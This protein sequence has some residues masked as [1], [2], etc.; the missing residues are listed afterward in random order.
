MQS[1]RERCGFHGNQQN[2]QSASQDSSRLE[3]YRHQSQ[4]GPNCERQ[5]QVTKGYYVQTSYQGY[6]DGAGEKYPRGDKH[7]NVQ[8]LQG[9][10]SF[11][12]FPEG[13]AYSG[14]Y[15]GEDGLQNWGQSQTL[16]GTKYEGGLIKKIPREGRGYQDQTGQMQ[17]RSHNLHHPQQTSLPYA[18][19]PRQKV[20]ND[21]PSS[22]LSFNQSSHF[23]QSFPT[24]STYSSVPGGSQ[25]SHSFKSCTAPSN[26]P[27]E[28]AMAGT[29]QRVQAMHAY[30]SSRMGSYEQPQ[31]H[32][33][34]ETLHYQ[35]MAKYQHYNQQGQAY[36][37][38][39][40]PNRT[41]EQYYQAFSPSSNHSPGRSV[42]RS[43]S[44]SSTPS[45][46]M[47]NLENFQYNQQQHSAGTFPMGI[48]E[49]SH[50]MPLLNPS[51]TGT[52]SPDSQTKNIQN[53]KIPETLLSDLSLQSLTALT[54]QVENISNTVQQLLMSKTGI[55]Q[56]K[57]LK[58]SPR[59]PEQMKGQHCSPENNTYSS[60]TPQSVQ[61]EIQ[62]A[63]YLSGSEDQ[64]ERTYLYCG[65]SRS[66]GRANNSKMKP[67]SISTCSVT[68]PD[69]MSTKSDDSFQSIHANLPLETFAKLVSSE[70]E[71]PHLLVN[72]LSHEELSTEII[73]LQDAIDN[74][75]AEK[76]WVDSPALNNSNNSPK[77]P[78]SLEN[79][80]S[81]VESGVKNTWSDQG[82]VGQFPDALKNIPD[83]AQMTNHKDF[84]EKYYKKEE[85]PVVP[86]KV[87]E[88]TENSGSFSSENNIRTATSS[89]SCTKFSNTIANTTCSKTTHPFD[90]PDKNVSESC[91]RW[92]DIE[93]T[94]RSSDLQKGMFQTK[95]SKINCQLDVPD[96]ETPL[97]NDSGEEFNKDG[98]EDL[99]YANDAKGD[100]EKW[101]ED[102]RDCYTEDEF[103]DI[104][105]LPSHKESA[106][107]PEDYSSLCDFSDR[108]SFIY[109][110][111]TPKPL[112]DVEAFSSV[113][114][115]ES[116]VNPS[117]EEKENSVPSS[118]LSDHSIILLGPAV[119][120]EC[121]VKSWF[122]STLSHI[123]T[124][125]D[126]EKNK[127]DTAGNST[128][129]STLQEAEGDF[130][131]PDSQKMEEEMERELLCGERGQCRI[132]ESVEASGGYQTQ[133]NEADAAADEIK[134]EGGK[135]ISL[136]PVAK[137]PVPAGTPARMCTRSSIAKVEPQ[138]YV[139]VVGLK[140]PHP[141]KLTKRGA[142]GVKQRA[143]FKPGRRG[144]KNAVKMVTAPIDQNNFIL[145][146]KPPNSLP[147]AQKVKENGMNIIK[148]ERSM[149]LRS[150]SKKQELF[151]T[152][153]RKG[154]RG[155]SLVLKKRASL[156]KIIANN[157]TLSDTFKLVPKVRK[158][159]KLSKA[160]TGIN[161]KTAE[162]AVHPL[163]R[164]PSFISP[165]P[166]KKRN[167]ILRGKNVK[168]EK[169]EV[170]PKLF[171]KIKPAKKEKV[172]L[173]MATKK[174]CKV[175]INSSSSRVTPEVC[176]KMASRSPYA[177]AMK[178]KV[179]PP[180]KG[181]G[182]KLEAIVQKITS[183]NQKKQG[184]AS[185]GPHNNGSPGSTP[186][187]AL[188]HGRDLR[189]SSIVSV[190]SETVM[191]E[192]DMTQN[193]LPKP[194]P[195]IHAFNCR[196]P[197]NKALKG[198]PFHSKVTT[199]SLLG[200]VDT[201][202]VAEHEGSC[203]NN[204]SSVPKKRI[205]R[206][207]S[208][209]VLSTTKG[210]AKKPVGAPSSVLLT[211]RDKASSDVGFISDKHRSTQYKQ[212]ELNDSPILA[213]GSE[214]ILVQTQTRKKN[215]HPALNGYTK[216]QRKCPPRSKSTNQAAGSKRRAKGRNAPLISPKEPEIK[217]RY[218]STKPAR[219]ESRI[220][221]F[222]PYVQ[223][224]RRNEFATTCT[225]IN[226]IGEEARLIKERRATY[227]VP[228]NV[229]F[230]SQGS[231]P[232]SSRMQLGPLVCKSVS[233]GCHVCCLCRCPANYKDLGD[234]C[235]PYY[236]MDSLP[237]KKVR[238]K[239][240]LKTEDSLLEKSARVP[241]VVWPAGSGRTPC[242]DGGAADS[243]K[244]S[245]LR[246][247][248]RGPLRKLPSCYCCSKKAEVMEAEKPRRHQCSKTA[249]PPPPLDPAPETQEH[250]VHEACAVWTSGVYLVAG[251]L[252]GIHEAIQMAST[253][254]CPKCQKPGAT[255]GCSHKGCAQSYHY[256]CATESGCL[257]NEENFSLRC[258]KHKRHLV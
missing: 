189:D 13:S 92:K 29:N 21:V 77:S 22:P 136:D 201:R 158:R 216:R 3:N 155:M 44:Y 144:G 50:Y 190:N 124:G 133:A 178:T 62:D 72:A 69:N 132:S 16:A 159:M 109:E 113:N 119:G 255:V 228:P 111:S 229:S 32:H 151:Q 52:S 244:S 171:K 30:Q 256:T 143:P 176:L 36:C 35:N 86:S 126:V 11:A 134:K 78:F 19:L 120:T 230:A 225:V 74:E 222:T 203:V 251:K 179:L 102:T 258:P 59:T 199:N 172:K 156:K 154:K 115:P 170:A 192:H 7:M 186:L 212:P 97:E 89:A 45:P 242:V 18:K 27:H 241:D 110:A 90:W 2:C 233:S 95:D 10:V 148:D 37:Q 39:E 103:N 55:P 12:S 239:E 91:L 240:R 104:P 254:L 253:G 107:E 164:K 81:C 226:T 194:D 53:D 121:K 100:D 235:G 31:R 181:R 9:R 34:Q 88:T 204:L 209:T 214:E 15:P 184:V 20:Q 138:T 177:G 1:F 236:P 122:E 198:K 197:K 75:K 129:P 101:L 202:M 180:R 64:L 5:R 54:T 182:L 71:C 247:S 139:P 163:K 243:V 245:N 6:E 48:N 73:A 218:V 191:L 42:G 114:T 208:K 187:N 162:R 63:D 108:K 213:D 40:T 153:R 237:N 130:K 160:S 167:V 142:F 185:L 217:L 47:P 220:R 174:K 200:E 188:L 28:R 85:F 43:P 227:S 173:S 146:G 128:E 82:A 23:N 219:A 65:P 68:S 26:P 94:L 70:R 223:V 83:K 141:E 125:G 215:K 221:H 193:E 147:G 117:M 165:V 96:V 4:P 38:S 24:A 196:G 224:E 135:A 234:L 157:C 183:P 49:H 112:R 211:S 152:K 145:Q 79:H 14:Q 57:G 169:T 257:L 61:T 149:I 33:N 210:A 249:E 175:I 250:W 238:P 252:Y 166:A 246:S 51:P 131:V 248:A 58:A 140:T 84:D 8:Q 168:E 161:G 66:P 116:V 231:L 232:G 25:V 60:G 118:Q 80:T 150:R 207:R 123:K 127:D 41:T 195:E 56:K 98:G 46:L 99:P 137:V 67:E 205:R 105:D 93:L 106:L 76:A 87:T 17:F 206:G